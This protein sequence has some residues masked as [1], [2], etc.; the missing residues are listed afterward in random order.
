MS[1]ADIQRIEQMAQQAQ[2]PPMQRQQQPPMMPQMAP[3]QMPQMQ[4]QFDLSQAIMSMQRQPMQSVQNPFFGGAIPMDFGLPQASQIPA[5][6]QVRQFTP[7][8]FNR[9]PRTYGSDFNNYRNYDYSGDGSSGS[10]GPAGEGDSPGDS[11]DGG[12]GDA[13]F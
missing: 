2:M 8:V 9:A 12:V 4:P 1:G 6:F 3:M 13:G 11:S 5:D 10:G 7:G